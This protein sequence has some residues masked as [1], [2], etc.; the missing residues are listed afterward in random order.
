M[1]VAQ[2]T[3]VLQWDR[4]TEMA[5]SQNAPAEFWAEYKKIVLPRD[6]QVKD[7]HLKQLKELMARFKLNC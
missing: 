7:F 1:A 4:Y 3:W 6:G 5:K 2:T